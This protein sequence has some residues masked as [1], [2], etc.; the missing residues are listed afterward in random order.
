MSNYIQPL[1]VTY[2]QQDE[3]KYHGQLKQL[4]KGSFNGL[5]VKENGEL[6]T[7][8]IF[9]IFWEKI[10]SLF[11]R[12]PDYSAKPLLEY[13]IINFLEEG[14]RNDWFNK[15]NINDIN[16]LCR[17]IGF[18][19]KIALSG[20]GHQCPSIQNHQELQ[21]LTAKIAELIFKENQQGQQSQSKETLS[22]K[23]FSYYKSTSTST[24][25]FY[26]HNRHKLFNISDERALAHLISSAPDEP[27]HETAFLD[28]LL[29]KL[30]EEEI[31]KDEKLKQS[32]NNINNVDN[33][34]CSP[35][36]HACANNRVEFAELFIKY[37]ADVNQLN[38]KG[39]TLL[40]VACSR[41]HF[42]IVERLIQHQVDINARDRDGVT[43]FHYACIAGH[44]GIVTLLLDN[45]VNINQPASNG[46]SPLGIAGGCG[47]KELVEMLL[48]KGANSS[49]RN[50]ITGETP[51]SVLK[52]A[53]PKNWKEISKLL[54]QSSPNSAHYA[55]EFLLRK[56]IGHVFNF[57]GKLHL[58]PKNN[59]NPIA[60]IEFNGMSG[61]VSVYFS[62]QIGKSLNEFIK[63]IPNLINAE[64]L[65]LISQ[66]FESD[67][68]HKDVL[69]EWEAGR[70]V[71]LHI[72]YIE[73]CVGM[74]LWNDYLVVCDR[75]GRYQSPQNCRFYTFHK[76]LMNQ[77]IINMLKN[78]RS[79]LTL[80][81]YEK[82][83]QDLTSLLG[84]TSILD[85]EWLLDNQIVGNCSFANKEGLIL[86]FLML[87]ELQKQPAAALSQEIIK[88]QQAIF[89][90][91]RSFQQITAVRKYLENIV[92]S[93]EGNVEPE[94]NMIATAL[95]YYFPFNDI[96]QHIHAEWE[97][98]VQLFLKIASEE[99]KE[100]YFWDKQCAD[101]VTKVEQI[102]CTFTPTTKVKQP[103]PP[104]LKSHSWSLSGFLKSI[105]W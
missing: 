105:F 26:L 6:T 46:I 27:F 82:L 72:G 58:F 45:G 64:A 59:N 78:S 43:A 80:V 36:F 31:E 93:S 52:E 75:G 10:K 104:P 94:F 35:L 73:H 19:N 1:L 91:W 50:A 90:N 87:W 54:I 28:V 61:G 97:K 18:T 4:A 81:E 102:R 8:N 92:N 99:G 79:Y 9:C 65:R 96:H 3:A 74:L 12:R 34:G 83:M 14:Y 89:R 63:R 47:H 68:E 37:K 32:L 53:R 38:N 23:I 84:T 66:A 5:V 21:D 44:L 51:L 39:E 55:N 11:T 22:S 15:E 86:A 60:T 2:T 62:R 49:S 29:P 67:A 20:N 24:Y 100:N 13:R 77:N 101:R 42:D 48:A 76:R 95:A 17:R 56:L 69:K 30:L 40:H 57:Q 70:P 25:K 98:G 103:L 7:A 88:K 16:A 71:V 85:E 41:G 33:N